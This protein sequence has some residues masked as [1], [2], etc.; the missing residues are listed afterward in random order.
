MNSRVA[1]VDK[2]GNN[3]RIAIPKKFIHLLRWMDCS[4]VIVEISSPNTIT[5]RRLIDEKGLKK[6]DN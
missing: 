5:I 3:F 2:A 4:H 1:K 6:A